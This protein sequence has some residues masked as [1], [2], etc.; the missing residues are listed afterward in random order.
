MSTLRPNP[1]EISQIHLNNVSATSDA[2][3]IHSGD[4]IFLSI[5]APTSTIKTIRA[6]ARNWTTRDVAV[7][8]DPTPIGMFEPAPPPRHARLARL[9]APKVLRRALPERR[10]HAVFAINDLPPEEDPDYDSDSTHDDSDRARYIITLDPELAPLIY[11]SRAD[12]PC[13]P[14]WAPHLWKHALASKWVSPIDSAG[15][16]AWAD[17]STQSQ[18]ATYI[19]T[20]LELGNLPI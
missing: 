18:V 17:R 7:I 1:D 19:T 6:S 4:L 5:I 13:L 9:Q 8:T 2:W 15:V 16:H 11:L 12:V 10:H 20:Q 3:V 14:E